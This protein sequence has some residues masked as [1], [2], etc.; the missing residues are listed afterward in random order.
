MNFTKERR[1]NLEFGMLLMVDDETPALRKK[2]VSKKAEEKDK[3]V[4]NKD[5]AANKKK[6]A[7]DST[8]GDSKSEEKNKGTKRKTQA[9]SKDEEK[10]KGVTTRAGAAKKRKMT[11]GGSS[12]A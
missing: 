7:C 8:P 11:E 4:K 6:T 10:D 9:A 12:V 2:A 1:E 3:D 5:G